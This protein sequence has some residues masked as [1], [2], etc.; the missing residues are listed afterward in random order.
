MLDP[1]L[2]LLFEQLLAHLALCCLPVGDR[3]RAIEDLCNFFQAATLGLRE[4]EVGDGKEDGQQT[5]KHDVIVPANVLHA[6]GVAKCRN[7]KRTVDGQQL[8]SESLGSVRQ[9]VL[10]RYFLKSEDLTD[11]TL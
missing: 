11:L 5:A 6:N 4:E 9:S 7:H 10:E 1:L 3:S 8:A 2:D